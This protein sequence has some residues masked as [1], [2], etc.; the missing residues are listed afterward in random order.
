L[1]IIDYYWYCHWLLLLFRYWYWLFSLLIDS[2]ISLILLFHFMIIDYWLL[3]ISLLQIIRHWW[4][5]F[6]FHYWLFRHW[7]SIIDYISLTLFH[8]FHYAT[9]IAFIDLIIDIIISLLI[10]LILLL[11]YYY[12]IVIDIIII[13]FIDA[14]IIH[15]W[16][17]YWYYWYYYFI[18]YFRL[19][20]AIDFIFADY[21]CHYF[22]ISFRYFDFHYCFAIIISPDISLLIFIIDI[23]FFIIADIDI[24]LILLLI[25]LPFHYFAIRWYA[26]RFHFYFFSFI[27]PRLLRR[28]FHLRFSFA[29]SLRYASWLFFSYYLRL[30]IIDYWYCHWLLLIISLLSLMP[31]LIRAISLTLFIDTDDYWHYT[32]TLL[33]L[34]ITPLHYWL[35]LRHYYWYCWC[36]YWYAIIITPLF[37]Y[38]AIIHY[39]HYWWYWWHYWYWYIIFIDIDAI[40]ADITL[41]LIISLLL[42]LTLLMTFDIDTLADTLLISRHDTPLTLF[43]YFISDAGWC[44]YAA[45][46]PRFHFDIDYFHF[47]ILHISHYWYAIIDITHIDYAIDA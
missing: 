25:L 17:H 22:I 45:I 42:T 47:A 7:Y 23:D 11:T 39:C 46:T 41:L 19:L 32:L 35:L 16:C 1:I 44:H 30:L 26:L 6:R 33:I 36:H 38:Y 12:A 4:H 10:T 5:W 37:H 9:L 27:T 18:D 13:D 40:I 2:L 24:S 14:D 21:D 34:I 8:Y 28:H 15:Y 29:L 43:H 3:I 31:L 20:L